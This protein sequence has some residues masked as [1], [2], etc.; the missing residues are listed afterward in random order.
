V[1]VR[2]GLHTGRPTLTDAG[3]VGLAVHAVNRICNEAHGGQILMSSATMAAL[4]P[5]AAVAAAFQS[6]GS[7]QLR[8]MREP[9][10]L[11]EVRTV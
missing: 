1:K 9:I 8:G 6:L 10:A 2:A 11:Y 7:R 4:A 5:D 3:Y